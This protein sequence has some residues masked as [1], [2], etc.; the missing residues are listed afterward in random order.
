VTTGTWD[1]YSE[2]NYGGQMVRLAPG[3]YDELQAWDKQISSFM[4]AQVN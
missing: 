3:Q 4:C 1:L 2:P